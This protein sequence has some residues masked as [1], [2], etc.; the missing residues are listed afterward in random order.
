[1]QPCEHTYLGN[2]N[3]VAMF[4]RDWQMVSSIISVLSPTTQQNRN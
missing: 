3:R 2:W 4:S 1:L